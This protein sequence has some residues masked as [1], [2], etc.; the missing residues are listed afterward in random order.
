[1][2]EGL[3]DEFATLAASWVVIF[4]RASGAFGEG[5]SGLAV[6]TILVFRTYLSL[7]RAEGPLGR[8]GGSTL[9]LNLKSRKVRESTVKLTR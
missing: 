6:E 5:D 8:E 3:M 7:T 9:T 2:V 1:M 4:V